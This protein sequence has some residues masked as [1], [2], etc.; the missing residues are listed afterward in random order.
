MTKRTLLLIATSTLLVLLTCAVFWPGLYGGFFFDDEASILLADGVRLEFISRESL[1]Q[2]LTS[3]RAGPLGRP[4]AQ[5]SFALNYFHNGFDPF[6]FKLTNL[7][8]HIACGFLV[9]F[10]TQTFLSVSTPTSK[11]K[12][13]FIC[14]IAMTCLWL[15]HPIQ[16]LPV[17]H[18]VQRMTSLSAL[19]LLSALLL[20]VRGRERADRTGTMFLIAA[21]VLFWPLSFLSKETGLLFPFFA[22]AWELILRRAAKK[23]L[24][25]FAR[26]FSALTAI[27]VICI[28]AYSLSSA[29]QW[30]WEGYALRDFTLVER[31]LTE[32]RVIWFYLELIFLPR[33]EIF[34]IYHDDFLI[35]SSPLSPWSTSAALLG[36]MFIVFIAWKVRWRAPLVSFAITWFLIGHAMEST[37]L[38][39]ELVHE[40]RNYLPLLGALLLPGWALLRAMETPNF[41]KIVPLTLTTAALTYLPLITILRANQFG[42]VIRRT[43]IEAQH[44]PSS[45]RTHYQAGLA[46]AELPDAAL[47]SSPIHT[48]S[49][50]HYERSTE[51]DVNFKFGLLGLIHLKCMAKIP[52]EYSEVNELTRRLRTPPFSPGDRNVLYGLTSM[53]ISGSLCLARTEIDNL[54][55]AALANPA[56]ST[57]ARAIVYSWHA[58]YLWLGQ[59]DLVAAKLALGK[60]LD[61]APENARSR[62]K[63]AQLLL[64]SGDVI[65][66]KRLL[67][68][69]KPEKISP[70]EKKTLSELLA[71]LN[72]SEH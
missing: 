8:I 21:W 5:L 27:T 63:W 20:H 19:F 71:R 1:L 2:A 7:A 13:I 53:S 59:H 55:F 28:T 61:L 16:T 65:A 24:D 44:H 58:D 3:A 67:T 57:G 46:L 38:P 62:F 39:L 70:Q 42:E 43:Q 52:G 34:A 36:L 48:F 66:A 56:I 31:M 51:L 41:S 35:S 32:G 12:N 14:S 60:S 17:L 54:F 37:I 40:H 4:I 9:F 72:I 33:L 29:G 64:A 45:A 26:V 15:I 18:V 49:R 23:H 10:L 11:L 68:T 22:L 47:Q 6:V 30:I 69:I 50:A 25:V